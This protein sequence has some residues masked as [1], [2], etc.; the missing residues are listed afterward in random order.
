MNTATIESPTIRI[1]RIDRSNQP[2]VRF[3]DAGNATLTHGLRAIGL[4]ELEMLDCE[5]P[6]IVREDLLANVARAILFGDVHLRDGDCVHVGQVPLHVSAVAGMP[7]LR[8]SQA[9]KAVLSC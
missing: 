6:A 1:C 9:G 7:L 4:H 2:E 3:I 8:I 5:G